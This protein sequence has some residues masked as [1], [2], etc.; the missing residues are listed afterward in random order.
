MSFLAEI[1]AITGTLTSAEKTNLNVFLPEGVKFITKALMQNESIVH[2][3]TKEVDI[4]NAN[5]YSLDNIL[6]IT[7]VVRRDNDSNNSKKRLCQRIANSRKHD[8]SDTNSIYFTNKYGPK[9]YIQNGT[10]FIYP[11]PTSSEKG[12][13]QVIEPDSS[14]TH[15]QNSGAIDNFPK[16]YERGVILY[17]AIQCIRKK[18]HD[19]VEPSISG[20]SDLTTI[21]AGDVETAAHRLDYPKWWDMVGD[22][23]AD[24]D[25]ELA[26]AT[27]QNIASYL[28]AY[29]TELNS[30]STQYQWHESQYI[31]L[32]QEL[33]QWLGNYIP[34]GGEE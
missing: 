28:G 17:S 32:Q 3:L 10:L 15:D 23:L 33:L 9:Y 30:S 1:E 24:E 5:G 2:Q 22:Y 4:T 31:K 34:I 16:E 27:L 6:N 12:E 14:V 13:L 20:G 21:E 8:L 18:M 11:D 7:E 19:T 25:I 29:Q 26:T